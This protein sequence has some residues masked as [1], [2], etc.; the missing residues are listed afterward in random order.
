M[1]GT[2]DR[3][4]LKVLSAEREVHASVCDCQV[5][6]E[7]LFRHRA[8]RVQG[9]QLNSYTVNARA[10]QPSERCTWQGHTCGVRACVRCR[11]A[12]H[13]GSGQPAELERQLL[14]Y[15]GRGR[16]KE[17]RSIDQAER[18]FQK[19]AEFPVKSGRMKK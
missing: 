10:S 5:E 8:L 3:V 14:R 17:G 4:T 11:S 13:G 19:G 12:L 15:K 6:L 16:L 9:R 1:T 7:W 2:Q 18:C